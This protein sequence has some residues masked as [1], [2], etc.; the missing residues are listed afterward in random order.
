M[1]DLGH[2]VILGRGTYGTVY[3]ARD[4]NTQIK[5]AIK[6]VPEKNLGDVQPLHEEIKLHSTLLH[7]NIVRYLGSLSE[8][9][10]FKIIMEQ[11]LFW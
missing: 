8:D 5:V 3:A 7:K 10:Y 6:E 9:G 1:D 11:V 4:L 2:K